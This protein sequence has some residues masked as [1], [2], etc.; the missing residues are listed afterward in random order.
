MVKAAMNSPLSPL[1]NHSAVIKNSK[2]LADCWETFYQ[3]GNCL[4]KLRFALL[5]LVPLHSQR[6]AISSYLISHDSEGIN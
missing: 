1:K 4:T 2:Y 3:D 5:Y 6:F